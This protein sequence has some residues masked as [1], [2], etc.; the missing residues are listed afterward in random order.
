MRTAVSPTGDRDLA[1]IGL[2]VAVL[3]AIAAVAT[4]LMLGVALSTVLLD[5]PWELP[6]FDTWFTGA[7]GVVAQPGQPA[8]GLGEPWAS[9]LS[10]HTGLYWT[11]TSML[12]VVLSGLMLAAVLPA[13]RRFGPAAAGHAK[14]EDVREELSLAAGRRTAAWTRPS[15]SRAQVRQ[16]PL[17]EVAVPLH[18]TQWREPM[19]TP[20]ENPTGTLAPTQSGKS[21]QDLVHK[22]IAAPGALLCSTTK[23][24]LLEFT[25]LLRVGRRPAA[26]VK[27]IDLTGT[28]AW[29]ARVHWWPMQ[30]CDDTTVAYRR[31]HTMVEAASVGLTG[32]GGND[33]VFRDR[34]KV[35]LQAYFL[36]A[37]THGRGVD[38]LVRWAISKPVDQEPV[39][40]LQQAGLHEYA[41]NLRS[42][43]GLVAETSDAVWLSVRRVIEPFMDPQIRELCTPAPGQDF[44]V[45]EFLAQQGSLYLI[46]GQHQSAQAAPILTALVEHWLTTAQEMALHSPNRR[47]DP[48][49]S[50][51]LD[52]ITNAT[53]VPQI[54]DII[55]DSAGR[56]VLIHW[57]AQTVAALED[58]FG[59]QRTRQLLDNTTTL[60]VWG[61]IKDRTTLEWVSLLTGHHDRRRY[62]QQSDGLLGHARTSV[63][64]ET[65]PTYRPGDVRRVRRGRVLVIHRH[66]API[67]ARTVDVRKRPDWKMICSHV[68]AVRDGQVE[69]GSDGLA[70]GAGP[71]TGQFGGFAA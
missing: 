50:A 32:V 47:L 5:G 55:S 38:D 25:A 14:R 39:R 18:L 8:S 3:S 53:P 65:V 34:A 12:L 66:L 59:T 10:S 70:V 60:S 67:L 28:V 57:G 37:A 68:Q 19:C 49:A 23:P 9:T 56:G 54:P 20:L 40:L 31:S 69:L 4:T 26:P 64:L 11:V 63:G 62:Q 1:L 27:L 46:A 48:P 17:E 41:R 44:D 33:K 45:R 42:E 35:V 22:V 30:G 15:L 21:R 61:G 13:W 16:A 2:I 6:G 36:A 43:I 71:R 7:L 58:A 52:E 29:P 51:I 24:D